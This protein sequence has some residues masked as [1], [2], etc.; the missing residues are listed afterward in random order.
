MPNTSLVLSSFRFYSLFFT[1]DSGT[2][3]FVARPDKDCFR[4][5]YGEGG[6]QVPG[7]WKIIF[8]NRVCS[9]FEFS[10]IVH[11]STM[12]VLGLFSPPG[13]FATDGVLSGGRVLQAIQSAFRAT[14]SRGTKM[15]L[16]LL[17]ERKVERGSKGGITLGSSV[18]SFWPVEV[19]RNKREEVA[20]NESVYGPCLGSKNIV[21][22]EAPFG[23]EQNDNLPLSGRGD[24]GVWM[25]NS[26]PRDPQKTT[27]L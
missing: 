17:V 21:G 6:E 4:G 11:C 9:V 20:P 23:R 7:I 13:G 2:R 14:M 16:H 22:Q 25:D 27:R 5:K 10:L 8:A 15:P 12:N 3:A 24:A 19:F 26:G 18:M 1:F